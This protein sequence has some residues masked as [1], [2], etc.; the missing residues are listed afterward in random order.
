MNINSRKVS[1]ATDTRLRAGRLL[2]M[3]DEDLLFIIREEGRER[4]RRKGVSYGSRPIYERGGRL[5]VE[6][7]RGL[8]SGSRD[9][10]LLYLVYCILYTVYTD[11]SPS[12]ILYIL[13][14]HVNVSNTI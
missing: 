3:T 4:K 1:N 2:M 9:S 11:T 6:Q 10:I 8:T 12:P 14:R 5:K 7:P 13:A